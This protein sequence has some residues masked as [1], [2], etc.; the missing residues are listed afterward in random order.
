M[1]FSSI[2]TGST[3]IFRNKHKMGTLIMGHIKGIESIRYDADKFGNIEVEAPEHIDAMVGL[4]YPIYDGD[5]NLC[6]VPK[7]DLIYPNNN[8]AS[9]Y[10]QRINKAKNLI[11]R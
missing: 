9:T 2:Q 10:W 11:G 7:D 3:P 6:P 4:G 5:D 8:L 1:R